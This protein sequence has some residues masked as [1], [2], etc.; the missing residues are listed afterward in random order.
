MRNSLSDAVDRDDMATLSKA[1]KSRVFFL[2]GALGLAGAQT[3][4]CSGKF[5]SCYETRTCPPKPH[6]DAG[7]A[8]EESG[9][10]SGGAEPSAG[11]SGSGR[12]GAG[13]VPEAAGSGGT[14]EAGGPS[15]AG[16]G[17]TSGVPTGG[18][19]TAGTASGGIANGGAGAGGNAGAGAGVSGAG[20]GSAGAPPT[21]NAC[22]NGFACSTTTCKTTCSA[23]ADCLGDHFCSSGQCRLDAVQVSI[24]ASHACILLA[25]KTVSCWGKNDLSQLGTA[26]SSA[27]AA[28]VQVKFLSGVQSIAAGE[29]STFALLDDGTVVFWGTR[30]TAYVPGGTSTTIASQ[31]PTAL[32][33][34]SA[35]KQIA[36]GG[37]ANGCATLA[38]GSVRCW[39]FNE[40]GQL[41]D[42]TYDFSVNPVV[43][44]GVSGATATDF[45]YA[46]ACAQS[47]GAVKCWGNNFDGQLGNYSDSVANTPQTIAGLSGAVSKLRTGDSFACVLMTNGSIQCWGANGSGQ[48]GNGT[49]GTTEKTPVTVSAI[50]GVID[51]ATATSHTCALLTGGTVRCWGDNSRGQVGIGN[52]TSP[53]TTPTAAQ[54]ISS[55]IAV[56]AGASTTCATLTNGSV[57]CWGRVVGTDSTDYA[58][59]TTIW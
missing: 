24:G 25:D 54:G 50:P 2:V 29:T 34:L 27:S 9:G 15:D 23:D 46:F 22:A 45:G 42:G 38:D 12:S 43:V 59:A 41:G 26:S 14:D 49:S 6:D 4:A 7:A 51:L 35:V 44:S 37:R 58:S 1:S 16:E 32:V 53:V 3:V 40:M 17:G 28:P 55:A 19:S 47:P 5:H 30:T 48:L 21:C 57:K 10:A 39:N 18:T 8:G 31:Y 52:T 36:A 13:G 20:G 33:G 11:A 56:S